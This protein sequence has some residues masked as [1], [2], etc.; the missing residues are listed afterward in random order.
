MND[1]RYEY[2]SIS[3]KKTTQAI[4]E[5][6]ATLEKAQ[7]EHAKTAIGDTEK[8]FRDFGVEDVSQEDAVSILS[9]IEEQLSNRFAELEDDILEV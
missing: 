5:F 7:A 1:G 9:G 8:Q 6:K 4:A 3:S 2:S